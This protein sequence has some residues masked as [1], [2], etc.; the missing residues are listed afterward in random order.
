MIYNI[1]A[2]NA[3][4][5]ALTAYSNP[6]VSAYR[7]VLTSYSQPALNAVNFIEVSYTLPTFHRINFELLTT[8]FGILKRW[9]GSTWVKAKLKVYG[10]SFSQKKLKRWNGS[11]WVEVDA[12]G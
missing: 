2:L 1:P 10:S 3:V 9:T 11:A 5:F 4:N 8:Y 6:D 12:A 7:S